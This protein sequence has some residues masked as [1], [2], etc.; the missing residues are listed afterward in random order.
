MDPL[1]SVAL[2]SGSITIL[3]IG[4][5][6][7]DRRRDMRRQSAAEAT[8]ATA[9][10]EVARMGT[11]EHFQESQAAALESERAGHRECLDLVRMVENA[12]HDTREQFLAFRADHPNCQERMDEMSQR[13][14]TLEGGTLPPPPVAEAAE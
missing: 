7:L 5:S 9:R 4:A 10:V 8:K 6:R 11:A 2:I 12:H 3:G 14:A 1:I 13:I